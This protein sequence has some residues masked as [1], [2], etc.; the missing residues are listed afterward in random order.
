MQ[1][2]FLSLLSLVSCIGLV[3]ASNPTL[4]AVMARP[5]SSK[6][7][8]EARDVA[9]NGNA[10]VKRGIF[11]NIPQE[12]SALESAIRAHPTS[13][14]FG[15]L[16]KREN[17]EETKRNLRGIIGGL[18]GLASS[19]ASEIAAHQTQLHC[20]DSKVFSGGNMKSK[21]Y[22]IRTII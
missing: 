14:P 6:R 19:L 10:E 9:G 15:A 1:L 13:F 17:K 5:T 3:S 22:S 18:P 16:E 7:D 20:R 8:F 11:G 4:T 2:R 12:I 21:E